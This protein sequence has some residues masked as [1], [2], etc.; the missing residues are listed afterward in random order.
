MPT[1]I[2]MSVTFEDGALEVGSLGR[3]GGKA[4]LMPGPCRHCLPHGRS[5]RVAAE[6][7][8]RASIA[9]AASR[10]GVR[11]SLRWRAGS[12]RSARFFRKGFSVRPPSTLKS[13]SYGTGTMGRFSGPGRLRRPGP[14]S[15]Q[16]HSVR[17]GPHLTAPSH[18]PP[19]AVRYCY[20]TSGLVGI[21]DA[22]K[23]P[24]S[25]C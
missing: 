9:R 6:V 20:G 4:R 17:A 25:R 3:P 11:I 22:W 13:P 10:P 21:P 12:G 24:A 8:V 14:R 16:S 5:A 19:P 23:P 1:F 7:A 18:G 15:G 2:S